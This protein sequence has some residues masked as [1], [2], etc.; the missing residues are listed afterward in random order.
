MNPLPKVKCH[1]LAVL[2]AVLLPV[3]HL[4]VLAMLLLLLVS[5]LQVPQLAMGMVTHPHLLEVSLL[6]PL[7][8]LLVLLRP[9]IVLLALLLLSTLQLV[10]RL[11]L[12]P[13]LMAHLP[14]LLEAMVWHLPLPRRLVHMVL[15]LKQVGIQAPPLRPQL[16]QLLHVQL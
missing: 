11:L 4:P 7:A 3:T 8:H 13:A 2:P 14:Q 1:I 6:L 12:P 15:R 9:A 10:L 16:C 5:R